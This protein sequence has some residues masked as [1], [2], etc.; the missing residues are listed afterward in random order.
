MS[1]VSGKLLFTG[2]HAIAGKSISSRYLL[3]LTVM[4]HVP[5]EQAARVKVKPSPS[6]SVADRVYRGSVFRPT[7]LDAGKI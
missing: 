6:E 1:S 3:V 5:R 4:G 2:N 7:A